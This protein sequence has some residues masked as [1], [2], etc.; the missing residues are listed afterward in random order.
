MRDVPDA[1][2]EA[3]Q[4]DSVHLAEIIELTT[5]QGVFRWTTSNA[6]ITA[7]GQTYDPFP[8][9]SRDGAEENTD[10]GVGTIDFLVVNSASLQ[11]MVVANAL[12]MAELSVRRVFVNSPDLGQLHIFRGKLGDLSY[13]RNTIQGQGRNLFNGVA[14][15]FPYYSYQ[16]YCVWRFGS[17]GCGVNLDNLTVSG[18]CWASNGLVITSAPGIIAASHDN[19]YFDRGRIRMTSGANSGQLR[20]IRAQSG[21]VMILSHA[22]PY[23]VAG[24]DT[25]NITPGCRKRLIE[26]CFTKYDNTH[27][28]MGFPWI[29]LTEQAF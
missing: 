11:A 20:T 29:P 22:L 18:S 13:D 27:R 4:G 19:N 3:L 12:D 14:E 28:F 5:V 9:M 21:D 24:G 15:K 26:D 16:P 17:P 25:Y 8:G 2:R 1:F 6:P 10:L 23:Q 7:A